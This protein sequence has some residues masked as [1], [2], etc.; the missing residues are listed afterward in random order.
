MD[1]CE[2]N[3]HM[4]RLLFGSCLSEINQYIPFW[5]YGILLPKHEDTSLSSLLNISLDDLKQILYSCG[6]IYYQR[7]TVKLHLTDWETFM[8]ENHIHKYYFDKFTVTRFNSYNTKMY[9]IGIGSERDYKLTPSSQFSNNSCPRKS[10]SLSNFIKKKC[11]RMKM[12]LNINVILRDEGIDIPTTKNNRVSSRQSSICKIDDDDNTFRF[13]KDLISRSGFGNDSS[14]MVLIKSIKEMQI[15][16][17]NKRLLNLINMN[18][19]GSSNVSYERL[20]VEET[21]LKNKYPMLHYLH[22]PL[23]PNVVSTILQE[24]FK[25]SEQF[26]KNN[27]LSIKSF[28]GTDSTLINIPK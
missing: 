14:I 19:E 11:N 26:P 8:L 18:V 24:I 2:S 7:D 9:Y 28:C 22:I 1:P 20:P 25:L 15:N 23:I 16:D 17:C 3:C 6:L 21:E 27:L 5:H 12:L 13:V 10:S 4:M